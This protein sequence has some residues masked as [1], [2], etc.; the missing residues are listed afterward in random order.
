MV[1]DIESEVNDTE[2]IESLEVP[3][4]AP[5]AKYLEEL[6]DLSK[7]IDKERNP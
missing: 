5:E 4:S 3:T 6:A 2:E 1:A 7:E